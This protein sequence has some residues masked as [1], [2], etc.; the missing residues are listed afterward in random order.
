MPDRYDVIIIGSGAGGK[1]LAWE[2]A[3]AGHRTAVVERK[4]IGGSCPNI[5]CL[6]SK[7]EVKSAEVADVVHHAAAFGTAASGV[8]TDMAKV[9]ARKRAMVEG[10]VAMYLERY[11]A[12]GAE[13][14][15][16][17]ARFVGE[18]TVEV[19]LNDGGTRR[20]TGDRV[21][22][23]LGTRPLVRRSPASRRLRS[24]TSNCSSSGGCPNDWS[25]SVAGTSGWS[26]RKPIGALAAAS[27]SSNAGRRSSRARIRMSP[28]PCSACLP[29]KKSKSC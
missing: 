1:H 23:N 17:Q 13:L 24:R 27:R 11:R 29:T 12:S 21:F 25:S 2:M 26:S 3:E 18:K 4:W 10:L 8:R 20:L 15:L 22:L 9:L 14:I 5:N 6:P 19:T 7:N 28:T 16:G